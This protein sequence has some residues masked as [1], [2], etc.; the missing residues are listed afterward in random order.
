MPDSLWATNEG[1]YFGQRIMPD[2]AQHD[3]S[4]LDEEWQIVRDKF[5][6]Y[7]GDR[8][9][10]TVG[11]NGSGKTRRLLI[12]NL[13]FLKTGRS[14]SSIPRARLLRSPGRTGIRCIPARSW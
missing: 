5:H 11:P 9:L 3:R 13:I 2:R 8:H 1:V 12:P 7:T 10:V 14:S 6:H 4:L